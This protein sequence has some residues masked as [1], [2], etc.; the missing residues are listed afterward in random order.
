MVE[1]I[2]RPLPGPFLIVGTVCRLLAP[3]R[4]RH[5]LLRDARMLGLVDKDLLDSL[6]LR[7][8]V[9]VLPKTWGGGSNL[10]TSEALLACRPIVATDFAFAGFEDWKTMPGVAIANEPR[11][12]WEKVEATLKLPP[13]IPYGGKDDLRDQLLWSNCLAPMVM[14]AESLAINPMLSA[15]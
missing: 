13:A 7:A 15:V 6:V 5:R 2:G 14:A 12:F 9:I 4:A 8:G 11:L 10:K 3:E 1:E